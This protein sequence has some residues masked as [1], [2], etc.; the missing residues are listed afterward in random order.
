MLVSLGLLAWVG[1]G[2]GGVWLM[3]QMMHTPESC[4]TPAEVPTSQ[5][6]GATTSPR[7]AF[8]LLTGTGRCK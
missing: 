2:V 4:G 7:N 1:I 8:Q 5:V 6:K 3:R